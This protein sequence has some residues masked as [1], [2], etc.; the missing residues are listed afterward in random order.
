MGILD[1]IASSEVTAEMLLRADDAAKRRREE[2]ASEGDLHDWDST[3]FA[4]LAEL[5]RDVDSATISAIMFRMEALSRLI[6]DRTIEHWILR[7]EGKDYVLA[8]EAIFEAAA[9]ASL[10]L[11]GDRPSFDP[12]EFREI[13]L[14]HTDHDGTA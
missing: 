12:A 1:D 2:D 6:V 9:R 13:A 5:S 10:D 11:S 8:D 4:V 7:V 14:R 3:L